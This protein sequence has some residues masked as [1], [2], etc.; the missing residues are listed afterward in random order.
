MKKFMIGD[1]TSMILKLKYELSP[2]EEISEEEI[3]D[4]YEQT[5]APSLYVTRKSRKTLS[6]E[7]S[8]G[9]SNE[10]KQRIARIGA[11]M[12]IF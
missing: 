7:H 6:E 8:A 1:H 5:R 10:A 9:T 12:I 4:S 11:N 2:L 3:E